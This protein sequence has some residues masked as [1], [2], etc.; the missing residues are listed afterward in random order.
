M[1]CFEFIRSIYFNTKKAHHWPPIVVVIQFISYFQVKTFLST[2]IGEDAPKDI[3]F[4]VGLITN[5]AANQTVGINDPKK[6]LSEEMDT[7]EPKTK[8]T[9]SEK[10]D[11]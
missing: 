6:R 8:K 10:I 1:L 11:M 9:K 7:H 4:R 2:E 3:D 5:M